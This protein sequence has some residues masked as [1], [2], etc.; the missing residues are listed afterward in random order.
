MDKNTMLEHLARMLGTQP[1]NPTLPQALD[2]ACDLILAYCGLPCL[3][4]AL[5]S[6]AV[7][8]AKDIW[9]QSEPGSSPGG[10]VKSISRGDV[11]TSFETTPARAEQT[12]QAFLSNYQTLLNCFRKLG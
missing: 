10:R 4:E 1:D 6:V 7:R 3:P 9:L 11:S 12:G 8:M 2:A 5:G